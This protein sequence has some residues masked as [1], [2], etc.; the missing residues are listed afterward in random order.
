[1][2]KTVGLHAV[3]ALI[4]NHPDRVI[5]LAVLQDRNDKKIQSIV[6]AA[7]KH[8]IKIEF[9]SRQELDRMASGENHQGVIASSQ[10]AKKYSEHDLEM[11]LEN[12]NGPAFLLILDG[13]QDPH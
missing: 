11:L 6:D 13:V 10:G 7:K 12:I 4:R 3:E 9:F 2:M 1:M 5:S 8:H